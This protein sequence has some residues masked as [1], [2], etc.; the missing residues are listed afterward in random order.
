MDPNDSTGTG[1]KMCDLVMSPYFVAFFL[2]EDSAAAPADWL[3]SATYERAKVSGA[4]TSQAKNLLACQ[5]M[6]EQ[7]SGLLPSE[8]R[9]PVG[10]LTAGNPAVVRAL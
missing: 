7:P 9:S 8:R 5:R 10:S 4:V 1:T 3:I 6:R 2:A